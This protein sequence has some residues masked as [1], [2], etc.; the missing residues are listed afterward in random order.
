MY[1]VK[2]PLSFRICIFRNGQPYRDDDRK[3]F[4]VWFIF[5]SDTASE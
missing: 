3:I 5:Q 2:D 1:N 4:V